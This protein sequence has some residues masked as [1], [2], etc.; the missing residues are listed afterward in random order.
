[1]L[2]ANLSTRPFYNERLVTLLLGVSALVVLVVTLLNL[3]RV[4]TLT[5]RVSALGAE[6]EQAERTGVDLRQQAARARSSVDQARLT[7]VATAAHEANTLIDR[8]T[9]SWTELFNRFEATL[10]PDVRIA[11][12][13]PSVGEDGDLTLGIAVVARSVDAIDTFIEALEETGA[14]EDVLSREER[15]NEDDEVEATLRG[16][17]HA[18]PRTA[19]AAGEPAR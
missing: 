12:V 13:R 5:A 1:M 3:Y 19:P 8:R 14:F 6:A 17:Y 9:F 10:P 15:I 7:A 18:G 11:A 4:V 2:R 16:R